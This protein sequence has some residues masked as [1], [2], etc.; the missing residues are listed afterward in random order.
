MS[1]RQILVF[2]DLFQRFFSARSVAGAPLALITVT[3]TRGS[4]YSKTGT[5]ILVDADGRY[6]GIVSGGCLEPDLVER[7]LHVIGTGEPQSVEYDL[8]D[9][10]ELFGLGIG[11]EGVMRLLIQKLDAATGYEP[12]ERARAA[13]GSRVPVVRRPARVGSSPG[14]DR[15]GHHRAVR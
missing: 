9:D 4:T 13:A 11:C 2:I 15:R 3:S 12:F 8:V 6:E 7:S 5:Q 1:N 10:D 14:A